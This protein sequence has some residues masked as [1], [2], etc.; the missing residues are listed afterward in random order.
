MFVGP[1]KPCQSNL[2]V[3]ATRQFAFDRSPSRL[4]TNVGHRDPR[5]HPGGTLGD[6]VPKK[7]GPMIRGRP[8]FGSSNGGRSI[9]EGALDRFEDFTEI[10]LLGAA[11]EYITT[12]RTPFAGDQARLAQSLKNLFEEAVGNS[13]PSANRLYA[14]GSACPVVGQIKDPAECILNLSREPHRS[15]KHA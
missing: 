11:C 15:G 14:N 4:P 7:I 12:P 6:V 8:V 9:A 3:E 5:Q 2:I 1:S 13:V 10:D